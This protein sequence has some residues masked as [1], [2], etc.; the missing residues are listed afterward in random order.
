L[1]SADL[2][3]F[4]NRQK[5]LLWIAAAAVDISDHQQWGINTQMGTAPHHPAAAAS[6]GLMHRR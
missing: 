3:D 2:S 1:L 5:F 4:E 6:G